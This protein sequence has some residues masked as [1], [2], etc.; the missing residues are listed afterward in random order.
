[1]STAG[2]DLW[3]IWVEWKRCC[4]LGKCSSAAAERLREFAHHRFHYY[5]RRVLATM[6]LDV[7]VD[8]TT[9]CEILRAVTGRSRVDAGGC[10]R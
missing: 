5:A 10:R 3:P 1:M 2:S 7:R 8:T 4:A 9:A 6:G